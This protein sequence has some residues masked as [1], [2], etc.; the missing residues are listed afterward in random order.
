MASIPPPKRPHL[1][2]VPNPDAGQV[3]ACQRCGA[4]VR[5]SQTR[6]LNASMH[7]HAAT[8]EGYC[9]NCSVA[10]WFV[11]VDLRDGV[12]VGE[13]LDPQTLLQPQVQESYARIMKVS[14]ADAD[15]AE[16]DWAKVARDWNL[17]F[18]RPRRARAKKP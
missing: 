9:V 15:P 5:V 18:R 16:I 14:G 7:R 17:P 8:P 1:R 11:A 13:P 2:L 4:E 6:N 3:T 12:V 10:E